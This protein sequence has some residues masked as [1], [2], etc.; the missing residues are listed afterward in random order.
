MFRIA[1]GV[2]KRIKENG[3]V[4]PEPPGSPNP[5]SS[6]LFETKRSPRKAS[7]SST[8]PVATKLKAKPKK[9]K[10]ESGMLSPDSKKA[11][12]A[13]RRAD[14]P[15]SDEEIPA[16]RSRASAT[17]GPSKARPASATSAAASAALARSG[18]SLTA[19][20]AKATKAVKQ[21]KAYVPER[22]SGGYAILLA[23]ASNATEDDPTNDMTKAE[24][25]E[26]CEA[27][28]WSKTS[29]SSTEKG[30]FYTAWNR[31]AV[32]ESIALPLLGW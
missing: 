8:E 5:C 19:A 11:K 21:P 22:S 4:M 3:G 10:I 18:E 7:F 26:I 23:L 24:I 31:L 28:G 12:L 25:I 32:I 16:P 29:F 20:A 2:E 1:K 17:A 6:Q 13:A 14:N 9:R 30:K 15:S 27:K